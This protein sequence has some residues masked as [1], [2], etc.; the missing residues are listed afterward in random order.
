MY[1]ELYAPLP[2]VQR[3]LDRLGIEMPRLDPEGLSALIRAHHDAVPFENYD[4]CE[5]H[6]PVSLGISELYDKIVTRR[7]GGY[8]FELNSLF[9]SLLTA[10]GFDAHPLLCRILRP[11]RAHHAPLH[12]ATVVCF[13]GDR[14]FADVGFG[15]PMPEGAVPFDGRIQTARGLSFRIIPAEGRSLDLLRLEDG[16]WIKSI[17][18]SQDPVDEVDF[19][20]ANYFCSTSPDSGFVIHR[21]ANICRPDGFARIADDSFTLRT[22][23]GDETRLI[24]SPEEERELLR[25]YFGIVLS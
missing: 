11:D 8:C 25:E 19:I 1:E 14:Y 15:G 10:L 20:P 3:Y 23:S 24:T 12:R 7:R 18:F 4:V 5:Y 21:M 9:C 6:T 22:A 13:G 2:D 16:S 17:Q